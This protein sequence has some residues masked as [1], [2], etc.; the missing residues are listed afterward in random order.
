MEFKFGSVTYKSSEHEIE[1]FLNSSIWE[2]FK[3]EIEAW[4]EDIRDTLENKERTPDFETL[5][6]LQ[7]SAE[8]LRKVLLM[9]NV[10]LD[11]IREDLENERRHNND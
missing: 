5:K 1:A 4:L 7:G 6:E 10:V 8:S 3:T 9:P 2:D 11:S